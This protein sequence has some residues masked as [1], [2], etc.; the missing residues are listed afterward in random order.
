MPKDKLNIAIDQDLIDS[1]KAHEPNEIIMSDHDFRE[2]LLQTILRVRSGDEK[3][4]TY[5]EAFNGI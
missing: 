4:H 1:A 3:W 2:S 5:Q